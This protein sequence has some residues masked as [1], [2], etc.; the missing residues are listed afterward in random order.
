MAIDHVQ[1]HRLNE[2]H[3]SVDTSIV[4]VVS[5][6]TST[7]ISLSNIGFSPFLKIEENHFLGHFEQLSG[8]GNFHL[9]ER[10]DGGHGQNKATTTTYTWATIGKRHIEGQCWKMQERQ[11]RHWDRMFTMACRVASVMVVTGEAPWLPPFREDG[12]SGPALKP[13]VWLMFC[14]LSPVTTEGLNELNEGG[15][16]EK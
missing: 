8:Y 10:A 11:G 2:P 9:V 7:N 4:A 1:K 14:V 15:G 6:S 12:V 5:R 3:W 13:R 16:V